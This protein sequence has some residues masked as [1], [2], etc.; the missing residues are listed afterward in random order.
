MKIDFKK[1]TINIFLLFFF[2]G[3]KICFA[4]FGI[5][6]PYVFSDNL[7]PGSHYEQSIS[8]IRSET[9]KEAKVAIQRIIPEID[10]WITIENQDNLKFAPGDTKVI[11]KV[12]IDV[13]KD[14]KMT[15]YKGKMLVSIPA[16]QE[17]AG[18]AS[19]AL[20]AQIDVDLTVSDK[21]ID[22]FEITSVKILDCFQGEDIRALFGIRNKGNIELQPKKIVME[23]YDINEQNLLD[24]VDGNALG[25]VPSNTRADIE[26]RFLPKLQTPGVYWAK[27]KVY[28]KDQIVYDEKVFLSIKQ[29]TPE[30]EA[31]LKDMKNKIQN[32]IYPCSINSKFF[33]WLIGLVIIA[34]I[35]LTASLLILVKERRG[36]FN[37]FA[38]GK[39]NLDQKN[40]SEIQKT[41][42][43]MQKKNDSIDEK[44]KNSKFEK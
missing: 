26:V 16:T 5:S 37:F 17:V 29:N 23:I 34:F 6:P 2:L 1:I 32:A 19:I 28:N 15:Q 40:I 8:L 20:G 35:L 21:V 9:E 41:K 27:I 7:M 3:I 11:M 22:D 38:K 14:A 30:R 18:G 43:A 31:M 4:G 10:S 39:N 13:P 42:E 33:Y 36:S 44:T 24:M 25:V 12:L